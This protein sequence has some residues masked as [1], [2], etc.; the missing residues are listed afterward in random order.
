MAGLTLK[1]ISKSFQSLKVLDDISL[2]IGDGELL[3]LLGPSGCGKSTLLRL[4]AGLEALDAGEI[5]LGDRRIDHLE[6]KKRQVAMVFQNYALYPHMSVEKNLAFPLK[7]AGTGK[8]ETSKS[9]TQVAEL[10]GLLDKLKDKPGQLSGGQR[11]RVALG[12]AIVRKP[13]LFLL[14]EPLSNLDAD[15]RTRMRQEIVKLQKELGITTIHVTHDQAEALT[16]ADRI[17]LLHD[18][19]LV[20]TGSPEEL[21]NNPNSVF[22]ARFIGSPGINIVPSRVNDGLLLPF[23]L[24]VT[25]FYLESEQAVLLV[26]L[27]PEAIEIAPGGDYS[28]IVQSCE[29]L[30]EQ[31]VVKLLFGETELVAS[32]S[33]Q[34]YAPEQTVS[35]SFE[36]KALLFFNY[37]SGIRI[38]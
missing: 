27:R 24:P 6:P 35:F 23:G 18:G 5:F 1:R 4:V 20:Q 30:G 10:L 8:E 7:V 26:G 3:V 38:G 15:L 31:Y 14:D 12:R 9:V 11:Q 22:V 37:E 16:M 2:E 13:A 21:Y 25:D 34:P 33:K 32:G 19:R 28:A 29:Y 17:A 36:S